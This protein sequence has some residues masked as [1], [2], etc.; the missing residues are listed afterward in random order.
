MKHLQN[1]KTSMAAISGDAK[2]LAVSSSGR[3]RTLDM[4]DEKLVY[5]SAFPDVPAV[6]MLSIAGMVFHQQVSQSLTKNAWTLARQNKLHFLEGKYE[7]MTKELWLHETGYMLVL[8]GDSLSMENTRLA[9]YMLKAGIEVASIGKKQKHVSFIDTTELYYPTNLIGEPE[10]EK[11]IEELIE[12]F[13]R[14]CMKDDK[15]ASISIISQDGRDFYAKRFSLKGH[16]PEP[17]HLNE[18]YGEGFVSF[19]D[20]LL[21]RIN[22]EKKGLILFHGEPGTGKTQFIR[23]LLD[24][25]TTHNKSILYAPPSLSAQLTEPHMIEF[26]SDWVMEEERDCILLI[27]DA[28]PLLETRNMDGR[29]TGIS[30]LLNI[31][32]GILN[33]MLGLMVIAT[34]N[35]D[36]GKIDSALLRPQRLIARKEF[37]KL[38]FEQGEAL[39]KALGT[40]NPLAAGAYPASLADFYSAQKQTQILLHE[41]KEKR[42][43]GFK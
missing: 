28:E 20:N 11:M 14:N 34:F 18:H 29:S 40:S 19:Y 25:L 5:H 4:F 17:I 12:L 7:R 42:Q 6:S 22:S 10:H 16:V 21:D 3:G 24:K 27:E 35:T 26:I 9:E 30:N 41:V 31:T 32:D 15:E 1:L 2:T 8:C 33:D 39:S 23:M 43:I 13:S 38:S 36:I 37:G